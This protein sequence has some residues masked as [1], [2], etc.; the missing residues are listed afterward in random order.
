MS[1]SMDQRRRALEDAFFAEQD[2][3]LR[4]KLV[5]ADQT[6][7]RRTALTE[8]SGI[9]DPQ[10]LDR[11][12]ALDIGPETL[13]ALSLV[14]LVLVAWADGTIEDKER[15]AVLKAAAEGHVAQGSTG[16]ELL[17]GWLKQP[18]PA[19]LFET[20]SHYTKAVA[21]PLDAAHRAGLRDELLGRAK[22][23]AESAGAFLGLGTAVSAAEAAVLRKL[24]AAFA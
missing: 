6:A 11:L 14:P 17:A 8:T 7:A 15:T 22:R 19:A 20:W 4:D 23:V 2:R 13:A 10:V 12:M 5:A 18:P 21:A 1:E 16:Y 9:T 24:E 3:K